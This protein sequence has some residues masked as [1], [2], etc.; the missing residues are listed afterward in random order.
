MIA[1]SQ[2]HV[3]SRTLTVIYIYH[4]RGHYNFQFGA[5]PIELT[6]LVYRSNMNGVKN[7]N[8]I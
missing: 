7:L 2:G 8:I 1:H 3:S 6:L 4:Q 5:P